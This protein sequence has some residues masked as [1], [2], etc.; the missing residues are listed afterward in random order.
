MQSGMEKGQRMIEERPRPAYVPTEI[1]AQPVGGWLYLIAVL[2]LAGVVLLIPVFSIWTSFAD[3]V[4]T[5]WTVCIGGL[6][7]LIGAQAGK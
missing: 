2:A 3:P 5:G 7:T 1:L 4:W 6:I